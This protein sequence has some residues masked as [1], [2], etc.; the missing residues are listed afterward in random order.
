M[1]TE[2]QVNYKAILFGACLGLLGSLLACGDDGGSS[3]DSTDGDQACTPGEP[4]ECACPDGSS[5]TQ[6]CNE[7]GNGFDACDCGGETGDTNNGDGDPG[8]GDPDTTGDGDP[9]TGDGDGDPD[10]A[11]DGD[12][13]TGDGDG[14]PPGEAPVASIFHPGD[15]ETRAVDVPIPFIGEALDVEDGAL[16]GMSIVWTSD[17]DGQIGTGLNFEAPL[18]TIGVHTITM[19]ATDSDAQQ[20]TDM[21]MLNM[22]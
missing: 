8:D 10:T 9:D 18:T 17:L 20:G 13:D 4:S 1:T 14:D 11:G 12:G 2:R 6:V 15:G 19:T 16:M 7:A 22:E 21:I 5:S 3:S